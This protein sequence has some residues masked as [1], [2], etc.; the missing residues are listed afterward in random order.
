[1][2]EEPALAEEYFVDGTPSL[3]WLVH[4]EVENSYY[5]NPIKDEIVNWVRRLMGA[6]AATISKPVELAQAKQETLAMFAFLDSLEPDEICDA[7]NKCELF[8]LACLLAISLYHSLLFL[9]QNQ[10]Q[11]INQSMVG[12]VMS[13]SISRVFI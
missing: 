8:S 10:N 12:G 13:P 9:N 6:A 7:Y 3:K 11:S 4:G 1:M 2:S 5:G